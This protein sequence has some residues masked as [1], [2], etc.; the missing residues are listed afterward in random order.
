MVDGS[1]DQSQTTKSNPI[2]NASRQEL[3]NPTPDASGVK[4]LAGG[5]A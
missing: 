1:A 3:L 4:N 2:K 5:R